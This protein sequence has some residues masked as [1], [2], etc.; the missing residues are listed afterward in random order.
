MR[1]LLA[2]AVIAALAWWVS[3][4]R[5][6][7]RPKPEPIAQTPTDSTPSTPS[8]SSAATFDGAITNRLNHLPPAMRAEVLRTLGMPD[9]GRPGSSG[10]GRTPASRPS[11]G[12]GRGAQPA[13]GRGLDRERLD[14][15]PPDVRRQVLIAWG[16]ANH[17]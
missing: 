1:I 9:P 4:I 6:P 7:T 5:T 10:V 11:D 2:I 14:R 3:G 15:L 16:E 12:F 13:P 8:A 17:P